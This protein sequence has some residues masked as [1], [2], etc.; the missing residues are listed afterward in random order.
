MPN[1]TV[2]PPTRPIFERANA[3]D[4][5]AR[6]AGAGGEGVVDLDVHDPVARGGPEPRLAVPGLAAV[7]ALSVSRPPLAT[8]G[9]FMVTVRPPVPWGEVNEARAAA[10]DQSRRPRFSVLPPVPAVR[11][12]GAAAERQLPRGRRRPPGPRSR[13]RPC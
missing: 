12:E 6:P 5:G 13:S 2:G 7:P 11:F 3:G 8:A 1:P 10:G 9:R 4:R